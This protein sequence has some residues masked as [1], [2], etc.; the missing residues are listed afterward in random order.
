MEKKGLIIAIFI[1]SLILGLV[2]VL[3]TGFMQSYPA[4]GEPTT[5]EFTG[6]GYPVPWCIYSLYSEVNPNIDWLALVLD[7]IAVS[8][9]IFIISFFLVILYLK[10]KK[11]II[12]YA[13]AVNTQSIVLL[14]RFNRR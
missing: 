9:L 5:F 1:M 4:P 7:I 2:I 6:Y 11:W 10:K 8:L 13:N 3:L 12:W 14:F